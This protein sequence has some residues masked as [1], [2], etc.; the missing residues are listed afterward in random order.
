MV[1]QNSCVYADY[2]FLARVSQPYSQLLCWLWPQSSV[3]L[4]T[5]LR[6]FRFRTSLKDF[7]NMETFQKHAL[8]KRSA[9][10]PGA[11][12]TSRRKRYVLVACSSS[13]TRTKLPARSVACV[14]FHIKQ[15]KKLRACNVLV[16]P[17]VKACYQKGD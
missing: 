16:V 9:S 14:S 3:F 10:V 7:I 15:R 6:L 4:E 12:Q 5:G 13:N 11:S 2:N 17:S 8:K 1:C